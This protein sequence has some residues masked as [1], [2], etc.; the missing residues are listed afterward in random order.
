MMQTTYQICNLS[1]PNCAGKIEKALKKEMKVEDVS[2]NLMAGKITL[3]HH[4]PLVDDFVEK[5]SAIA[6]AIEDGVFLKEISTSKTVAHLPNHNH[7][8]ANCHDYPKSEPEHNHN[9]EILSE[10]MDKHSHHKECHEH[11]HNHQHCHEYGHCHNHSHEHDA[12]P[13][14][15][16][17][18]IL[19]G[20]AVLLF[21]IG[22]FIP[23]ESWQLGFF[24]TAYL[25]AGKNV[26]RNTIHNISRGKFL[27]E[28][29]LM[30]LA[31][32]GAFLVGAQAEGAATMILYV[33]GEY[34]QDYSV[35]RSQKSISD[36]MNL[37]PQT[38]TVWTNSGTRIRQPEEIEIGEI[39]LISAG[40]KIA[41]DGIIL[42]GNS[43]IDNSA[44]TGESVPIF[45]S[46]GEEVLSGGLVKDGVL[47]VK[48]T[49]H[50]SDSTIA[51]VLEMITNAAGRKANSERLLT[52]FAAYYTPAVVVAAALLTLIPVVFFNQSPAVWGYRSLV[53]LAASCPCALIISIPLTYFAGLGKA[54]RQGILIKGANYLEALAHVDTIVFDKTGTLTK[55]NFEVVSIIPAASFTENDVLAAAALAEKYSNHPIGL[56]IKKAYGKELPDV[57]ADLYK[58]ISGFGI[59]MEY[60][61]HR[62]LCGNHSLM[63]NHQIPAE[64]S[65]EPYT[66]IY[67]AKDKEFLGKIAI[68]DEIKEETASTIQ[69]L[70][71]LGISHI[72]MFTGDRPEIAEFVGQQIG[73]S[74]INAAMLPTDK[75]EHLAAMLSPNRKITFV[76]DGIN[77]AS[78]IKAADIGIAMGNLGSDIAVESAD[79]I[80]SNDKL[81]ALVNALR[82]SRKTSVI[83]KQN[84]ILSLGFKFLVLV[85]GAIGI[86]SMWLAIFADV[87]IMLLASAN[88]LRAG[89]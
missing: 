53:F 82:I 88:A 15:L 60:E 62:Y 25:L 42:E 87:G 68:A 75:Y 36:L 4:Q 63:Q 31:S 39:L 7:N 51:K 32:C 23:M 34:I 2:I 64:I 78:V 54:S 89:K 11:G 59:A 46:A 55:G 56:S 35:Y 65:N 40:E 16:F 72:Q 71:D 14:S 38:A 84:L 19:L 57:S 24:I 66:M 86:A 48:V 9:R 80:L 58:D 37:K 17:N 1:C 47:K 49:K 44:L 45:R 73:I 22:F 8:T 21:G 6:L 61:G 74:Q 85:L 41:L 83:L 43:Y 77:D 76:G 5:A 20:S 13:I 12:G 67:V 30:L 18:K 3:E 50:Y 33:I 70:K 26:F 28:N 81:S 69:A 79:I 52:R 29:V 27:D 10:H